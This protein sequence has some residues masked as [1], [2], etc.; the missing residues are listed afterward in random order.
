MNVLF[1]CA[2]DFPGTVYLQLT[3]QLALVTGALATHFCLVDEPWRA[4]RRE[5]LEYLRNCRPN[6]RPLT[7]V[8]YYTLIT[9]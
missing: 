1:M 5:T 6:H 9:G 7:G 4:R 3:L 8:Q 2:P